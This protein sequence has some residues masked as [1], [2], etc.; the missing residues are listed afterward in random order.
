MALEDQGSPEPEAVAPEASEGVPEAAEGQSAAPAS[1]PAETDPNADLWKRLESV[2][3]ATLPKNVRDR[4][5]MPFKQD[6]TQKWQK[7]AEDKNQFLNVLASR[8]GQQPGQAP[9]S[10]LAQ[11]KQ[12]VQEGDYSQVAQLVEQAVQEKV[13]PLS[14]QMAQQQAFEE[15]KRLHPY[16]ATKEAEI[17]QVL[18][19]NPALAQLA[20]ANN[21]AGLPVVLQGIALHLESQELK[22][23][24]AQQKA[25]VA[26]QVKAGVEAQLAKARGVPASTSKVGNGSATQTK[27]FSD[28]FSAADAAWEEAIRASRH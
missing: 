9:Q 23:Q 7:L 4:L 26:A 8:L 11:L 14:A 3:P 1:P 6:Y 19:S 22:G 15:A 21:Y 20:T 13:G 18:A 25:Q 17:S 10:A 16:V 12:Q 24:L 27:E 28:F 2:D 5:E